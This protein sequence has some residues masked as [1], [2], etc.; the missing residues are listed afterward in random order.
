M[1]LYSICC[2]LLRNTTLKNCFGS[3]QFKFA[4]KMIFCFW[5]E[6]ESNCQAYLVIIN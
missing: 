3:K 1:V 5:Y 2:F 6:S 4:T